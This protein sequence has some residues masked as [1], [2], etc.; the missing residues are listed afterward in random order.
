MVVLGLGQDMSKDGE[1][2]T[3]GYRLKI[4]VFVRSARIVSALPCLYLI[5]LGTN[6][7]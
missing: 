1:I 2:G 6:P 7:F 5:C 3:I 4:G